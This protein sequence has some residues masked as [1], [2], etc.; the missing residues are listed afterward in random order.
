MND[1]AW[2]A[3]KVFFPGEILERFEIVEVKKEPQWTIFVLEEKNSPPPLPPEH[4]GKRVISKG[5]LREQEL[6]DFP[7]R[8]RPCFLRVRRRSWEIEDVP[9]RLMSK[10]ELRPEGMLLTTEF[11]AFLKD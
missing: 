8:G 3:L 4:R 10:I 9:G 1:S 5:F 2:D 11:A 6:Q 7:V